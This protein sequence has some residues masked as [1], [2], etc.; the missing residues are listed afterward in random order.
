MKQVLAGAVVG[1]QV[2]GTIAAGKETASAIAERFPQD[3]E[4]SEF[5]ILLA[6]KVAR[7]LLNP[8]SAEFGSVDPEQPATETRSPEE[9]FE[10]RV[11]AIEDLGTT[12][13]ASSCQR[14]SEAPDKQKWLILEALA[15]K[16]GRPPKSEREASQEMLT[17]L[18]EPEGFYQQKINEVTAR[19]DPEYT[20]PA[21]ER[22]GDYFAGYLQAK[23][24]YKILKVP[25]QYQALKQLWTLPKNV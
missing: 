23:P 1:G 22:D 9:Q 14:E 17:L 12:R 25:G 15:T 6:Q 4:A 3:Q 13:S 8:T 11:K 10:A 5:D 24:N 7:D 19:A 21:I 18:N 2:G 16:P 20:P